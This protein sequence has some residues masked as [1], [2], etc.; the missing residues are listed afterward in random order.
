MSISGI[1]FGTLQDL[2]SSVQENLACCIAHA[3][4]QSGDRAALFRIGDPVISRAHMAPA[5]TE[6][7]IPRTAK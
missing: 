7:T 6:P 1:T 3:T 2:E 5:G 4:D